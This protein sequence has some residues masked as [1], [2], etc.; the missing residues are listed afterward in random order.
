MNYKTI[1]LD[2]PDT[3]RSTAIRSYNISK[4]NND[5]KIMDQI[6]LLKLSIK[7][8]SKIENKQSNLKLKSS[9]ISETTRNKI[10]Q[11]YNMTIDTGINNS[12]SPIKI[13]RLRQQQVKTTQPI[14]TMKK[15]DFKDH[16]KNIEIIKRMQRRI[17][18]D[19]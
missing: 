19:N 5:D 3:Y 4:V 7:G 12:I 9:N 14:I 1:D 16:V 8:N 17:T 13:N 18:K 6:N 2:K 15:V 11:L 10:N